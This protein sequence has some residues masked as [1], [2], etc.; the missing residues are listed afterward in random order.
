M[1]PRL[2][3]MSLGKAISEFR[4]RKHYRQ[5]D[6]ADKLGI[7]QTLVAR[8]ENGKTR[9]RRKTLER[10]AEALEVSVDSLL[11][12][13]F[14]RLPETLDDPELTELIQNLPKL[15]SAQREAL[16]V[17]LRDL[18]KLSELEAVMRR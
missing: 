8:W 16:K 6:L 5:T 17:F 4:K 10:L 7:H 12:S 15:S 13:D 3:L 9:P 11:Q 1:R 18:V 14:E 2:L